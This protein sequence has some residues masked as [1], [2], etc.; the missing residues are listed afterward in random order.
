M[1]Q[2]RQHANPKLTQRRRDTE[3]ENTVIAIDGPVDVHLSAE[4]EQ[5]LEC[6]TCGCRHLPVLYTRHRDKQTIRVRQCRN[7]GRR[8]VTRERVD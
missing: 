6:P 7:C 4:P 1:K 8:I 5:G 2:R 3:E